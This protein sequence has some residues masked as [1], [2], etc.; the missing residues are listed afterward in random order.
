MTSASP[1]KSLLLTALVSAVSLFLIGCG[2]PEHSRTEVEPAQRT[3]TVGQTLQ[4]RAIA[5]DPEGEEIPDMEFQWS[6]EGDAAAIS[7]GGLLTA[8][9][10]GKVKVVATAGE[11]Q[12]SSE[13]TIERQKVATL[14]VTADPAE[15]TVGGETQIRVQ[16]RDAGGQGLAGVEVS[17]ETATSGAAL[18]K[19][20]AVTDGS[21]ATSF[22]LTTSATAGTNRV[23]LKADDETAAIEIQGLAGPP[24]TVSL[25]LAQ[26]DV[27]AAETVG[28]AITVTDQAGNAVPGVAVRSSATTS[29]TGVAPN[30]TTTNDEGEA[31]LNVETSATAGA[32][33]IEVAVEGVPAETL[34]FDTQAG[35]PATL[36]MTPGAQTTVAGGTID[37]VFEL[38]DAHGN[39]VADAEIRLESPTAG[40]A[41]AE[42]AVSTDAQGRAETSFTTSPE[43]GA[44]EIV[45]SAA[46]ISDVT[47]SVTGN[48]PTS[49]KVDPENAIV[50]MNASRT[51]RA[52]VLDD[53]G[54]RASVAADWSVVGNKGTIDEQGVFVAEELGGEAV[55]ASYRGLT[56]GAALTVTPGVPATVAISPQTAELVSGQNHQFSASVS[57]AH[58]Y[59]L[60]ITPEWSVTGNVGT[61]DLAGL[62]TATKAGSGTIM[63]KAGNASAEASVT[64]TPGPLA[65]IHVA[66]DRLAARAGE[67]VQL[68]AEGRDASDNSVPIEPVWSLTADL[69]TIDQNGL[70]EAEHV[71][72]GTIRVEAGAPPIVA[73][74]PVEVVTAALARIEV[75]PRSLTLS[76]GEEHVFQATGYDA[77]NNILEVTPAWSIT[78][79]VG[80]IDADG[81]LTARRTGTAR[82]EARV[83]ELSGTASVTVR[84]GKLARLEIEPDGPFKLQAG[85]TVSLNLLG[86]D[87]FG[88]VVTVKPEWEQP[89][90]LGGFE[91]GGQFRA[92]TVGSGPVI[93]RVDD[94]QA[95]VE[96]TV[97]PGKLAAIRVEPESPEPIAG[98]T[99]QFTAQGR[100]A[101]DNEIPIEPSW[102]VTAQ[103][104][105][106]TADGT[107]TA[108]HARQG[109]VVAT[110]EGVSGRA[111]VTVLPSK[112][113][114]FKVT[115]MR[116]DVRAGDQLPIVV[117]G[118]DTYGNP[119]PTHP[120]WQ[121]PD[122][123]GTVDAEGVFTARKAGEGRIIVAAGTLAAVIDAKV[124]LGDPARLE[125]QPSAIEIQS[126]ETR[127][128]ETRA[129]D[130]GGNRV[131]VGDVAWE[132]E[133]TIGDV[134][135][136]G[137]FTATLAGEGNLIARTG[138]LTAATPVTV[139]PGPA[140]SLELSPQR[141]HLTAGETLEIET[142]AADAAGNEITKQPDW[143]MEGNLGE[144]SKS[145]V[146]EAVSAGSGKI[147]GSMNDLTQEI[148]V[149]VAPGRLA[150]IEIAPAE[151]EV[152]AGEK[153]AFRATG[154]DTYGNVHSIYPTWSLNGEI[155]R[156]HPVDGVFAATKAGTGY[157][158]ATDG[159]VSGL[160]QVRVVPGEVARL[161]I[162]PAEITVD[163]GQ[164]V[165]FEVKAYDDQGNPRDADLDWKMSRRLGEMQEGAVFRPTQ[166]GETDI[167][168]SHEYISTSAE[169]TVRL[170]PIVRLDVVPEEFTLEAGKSFRAAARGY[171]AYGNVAEAAANWQLEGAIGSVQA[172]SGTFT[173][174]K[175]GEGALTATVG[176]LTAQ[177]RVTT[178]PGPVARIEVRP[179]R[180]EVPSTEEEVFAAV[181]FDSGGNE[182]P[183]KVRWAVN[184]DLGEID[185]EGRFI[186]KGIGRGPVVA[187]QDSGLMGTAQ[188][189]VSAGPVVLMF[190]TPQ[191]TTVRAGETTQFKVQG[192][193]ANRN[194]VP[195]ITADWRTVGGIGEIDHRTGAFT[196]K[197]VGW[198]KVQASMGGAAG[199]ADVRVIPGK[200]S[201]TQSRMTSSLIE[202]PADGKT[203]AEITV[204]ARDQYGNPIA[205]VPVTLI[206]RIDDQIEQP[207]VT[208]E[209]GI[210]VGTI[211]SEKTGVSELS[212]IVG[213]VRML[214][215]LRLRFY[216]PGA[217]G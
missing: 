181:G 132:V 134:D 196:A 57:N 65:G 162:E 13:I 208:N 189:S 51:F 144:I 128:F 120:V 118:Y 31:T 213:S 20:S 164:E 187:Y 36:V 41:I 52:L 26:A 170:G 141:A 180:A 167:T 204:L 169:V 126:G 49:L 201:Q 33:T 105:E 30:E 119:V 159:Y 89:V 66:P 191:P 59:A 152:P 139:T 173:A 40:I 23:E 24:A 85:E 194:S 179:D 210:A 107:F 34:S 115:P 18:D 166:T 215:T 44:N 100:D 171:D 117:V 53:A 22:T 182:R 172:E 211:R 154:Y 207:G 94:M 198:G 123:L 70:F 92:T 146:F 158:I 216:L 206:G 104:G 93:A 87:A 177:T 124:S 175:A 32:N 109:E 25:A 165:R 101:Y 47:V 127:R 149:T 98:S 38:S 183:V 129:F 135:A 151:V 143:S 161:E 19:S 160:A 145:G 136:D 21:G 75:A 176:D 61:V 77:S 97:G 28:V 10:P 16:A 209:Q 48:P 43:P 37:L 153:H 14:V 76:A 130:G 142:R 168:V 7:E 2:Q 185:A 58:G 137:Q 90:P 88:N 150:R 155:G 184:G 148:A 71:G 131:A 108:I 15:T 74:I 56:G 69:G 190:V 116:I 17:A 111:R 163:A 6:V 81:R 202:V 86:K 217:A 84:P 83:D 200:P 73:E 133:G 125:I 29:G 121:I 205:D 193:D 79:E 138:E 91:P 80:T 178:V 5:R 156:L 72:S 186:A 102:R 110:A 147:I 99:I 64:V 42:T 103:I 78:G 63:A 199:D 67:S 195:K 197:F 27:R 112:L 9:T 12:G 174:G 68:E 50:E 96:M 35:P 122:D 45:A 192:F 95:R 46:G 4:L 39:L 140:V 106:I 60:D 55:V 188:V 212:G 62:F 11:V 82:V 203:P 114:F 54:N 214:N 157:V 1:R 3:I 8:Q 113:T